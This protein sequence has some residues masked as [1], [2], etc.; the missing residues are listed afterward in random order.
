[1]FCIIII[2]DED[3]DMHA[4]VDRKTGNSHKYKLQ[5]ED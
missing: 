2:I 1:M 3:D 5:L 4:F